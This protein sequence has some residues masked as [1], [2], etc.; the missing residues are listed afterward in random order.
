M[1][2][3]LFSDLHL[4]AP[5]RWAGPR[6][7]RA[8][9]RALRDTL[10]RICRLAVEL[11]ADA[12]VCGG[13][14]FEHDRVT[15][16]TGSF[17]RACLADLAPTP[18]YLT[19]GNHDWYGPDSLYRRLD[20]PAHVHVFTED[21]LFPVPLADG[22]TLWG[23][24][25]RAP[26]NTDGFLDGFAVDRGGV[27]V[28]LFHGS[29]RP[30]LALQGT[31]KAPHAP[32]GPDQIEAAGLHHALLGHFHAPRDAP[33]HTYPGNPEPL[34]FG[35]SGPRGA[36]LVTVGTGGEVHRERHPVA[37]LQVG[38]VEVRLD[39]IRHAE[40]VRDRVA[41]AVA[42]RSGV[43]RVTLVGEVP[44]EVDVRLDAL[45]GVAP[46][47]DALVPR[48]GAVHVDYDIAALAKER[49]VRGR[50]VRDVLAAGD[51]DDERRRR[52]LLTGLRALDGA[53]REL[54][55]R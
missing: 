51:L 15:P 27:H 20:W 32:F 6:L 26:A 29:A 52:V 18:V 8:R 22:L 4:D 34:G 30:E 53:G 2:L 23:A 21:R 55:V 38:D 50:F 12:L 43:V 44:P 10:V 25:H 47:L 14:L 40:E 45:D 7:A 54:A 31:G 17:L 28:A 39:G 35:E 42:G 36:V 1:R 41:A 16:D 24:A 48:L 49:T 3:L 11:R 37:S 46:H 9:R 19:P 5:F 13:D 33:R